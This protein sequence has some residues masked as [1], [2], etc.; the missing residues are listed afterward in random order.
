MKAAVI[1]IIHSKKVRAGVEAKAKVSAGS[2]EGL[3]GFLDSG[4]FPGRDLPDPTLRRVHEQR[5]CRPAPWAS[6]FP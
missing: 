4:K 6:A 2:S 5:P 1:F 3:I